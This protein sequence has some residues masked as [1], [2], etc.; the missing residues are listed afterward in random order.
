MGLNNSTILEAIGFGSDTANVYE[1]YMNIATGN[2]ILVLAGAVPGY[3]VTVALCDTIGRKPIQLGGFAILT[4]L[5]CIMGFGYNAIGHGGL[6]ACYILANFFF[7]FGPNSTTFIVPGECFPTRYRSTSHGISAA[8]GK[9]GAIIAQTLIGPLR[10]R[11]A[12]PDNSSPWLNH[13]LEIFALFM[14][15]GIFTTLLIPETKRKTLEQLAGE[16]PGTPEYDPTL[17]GLHISDRGS[18]D[19]AKEEQAIGEKGT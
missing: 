1:Y 10:V 14:L 8:S 15:C 5:F 4:A 9:V 18:D 3:W 11:G 2:I 17:G 6:F 19:V 13:V 16:V 12:T 7:N